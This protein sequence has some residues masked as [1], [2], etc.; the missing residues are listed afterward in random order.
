VNSIAYYQTVRGNCGQT[1]FSPDSLYNATLSGGTGPYTIIWEISLDGSKY[2]PITGAQQG[3]L[4]YLPDPITQITW[5][6]RTV[7]AGTDTSHSLAYEF[8]TNLQPIQGNVIVASKPTSIPCGSTTYLP[9]LLTSTQTLSGGVANNDG[10]EWFYSTDGV[11]YKQVAFSNVFSYTPG[12]ITVDT[13]F[14]RVVFSPHQVC[15]DSSNAIHFTFAGLPGNSITPP[16]IVSSC[17]TTS[18]SPGQITGSNTGTGSVYQWQTGADSLHFTNISGIN[19]QNYTPPTLTASAY[20]RRK[21]S[22]AGCYSFSNPVLLSVAPPLTGD[23]IS[24]SQK[25]DS[26]AYPAALMGNIVTAGTNT[27]TYLWEISSDSL[28]YVAAPGNNK[29]QNYQPL[30]QT[31]KVYFRREA[32]SGACLVYS[33]IV[34]ISINPKGVQP[35]P[36]G[37]SNTSPSANLGI[38]IFNRPNNKSIGSQYDY[39]IAVTNFGPN[40]ATNIVVKD[41]LPSILEYIPAP[42]TLGTLTY[43]A[44]SRVITWTIPSLPALATEGLII[45][46]N[47]TVN[48]QIINSVTVSATQCDPLLSNNRSTDTLN[49]P[50]PVLLASSLHDIITPNGD[51]YNDVFKIDSFLGVQGLSNNELLI[52]DR[53]GNTVYHTTSYQNDWAGNGLSAGTYF[54]VLRINN[55]T[56]SQ[57]FKGHITLL[58]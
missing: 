12:A 4:D 28:N 36:P 40:G 11:N 34:V 41:T 46:V 38:K 29:G 17:N 9:G 50:I 54:Y 10:F 39:S 8:Y 7:I 19:T 43:D 45:T 56:R 49:N 33:N 21:A 55:G 52:F 23:T 51:G 27:I 16:S 31:K 48:D 22:L 30:S 44:S 20:F 58:R 42:N 47:P 18:F 5:F 57:T 1:T 15:V 14:K 25:I 53:W 37:C 24:A 3:N 2:K 35:P 6:R 32:F 26:A 13:W